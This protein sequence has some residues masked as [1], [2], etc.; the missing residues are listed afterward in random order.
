[1]KNGGGLCFSYEVESAN[2][3]ITL[4]A[5]LGGSTRHLLAGVGSAGISPDPKMSAF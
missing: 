5:N 2:Q 4:F 3:W 1:M